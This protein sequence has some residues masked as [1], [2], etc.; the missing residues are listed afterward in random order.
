MHT[1][2]DCCGPSHALGSCTC[3]TAPSQHRAQGGG[4]GAINLRRF[5]QEKRKKPSPPRPSAWNPGPHALLPRLQG[6]LASTF[7]SAISWYLLDVYW[8]LVQ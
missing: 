8:C 4:R 7:R 5:A 6:S 1:S 3:T 2:Q